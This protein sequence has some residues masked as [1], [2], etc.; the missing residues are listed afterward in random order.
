ME[1]SDE[2]WLCPA[3]KQIRPRDFQDPCIRDLPG[4][5]FAC[6]GHGGLGNQEGYLLFENG[7]RLAVTV[8]S[9][10]YDDGRKRIDMPPRQRTPTIPILLACALAS[11]AILAMLRLN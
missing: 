7:V 11:V 10:S 8:T 4:V 3:C 2:G 5:R 1:Q 6:C 9:I